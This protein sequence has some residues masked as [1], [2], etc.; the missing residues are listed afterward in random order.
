MHEFIFTKKF[1]QR[2]YRHIAFWLAYFLFA[3]LVIIH[4]FLDKTTFQKWLVVLL[5]ENLCHIGTQIFFCYTVLYLLWSKFLDKKKYFAFAAGIL[6]V[7]IDNGIYYVEHIT[8]FKSLHAYAGMPFWQGTPLIF[9]WFNFN[10]ELYAYEYRCCN[11][12]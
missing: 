10:L 12:H 1:P 3:T 7:N 5:T 9:D 8:I 2:L 4:P 11:C 6:S